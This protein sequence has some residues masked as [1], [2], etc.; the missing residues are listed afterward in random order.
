M[1]QREDPHRM[2]LV[3]AAPPV[4]R[5]VPVPA[6]R[7]PGTPTAPAVP[8]RPERLT[9]LDAYRGFIMLAMA[10]SS[11]GIPEVRAT[12]AKQAGGGAY[13]GQWLWDFLAYQ[14][15]HAPWI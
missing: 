11:L 12:L 15:D 5:E 9:S 6:P 2:S 8:D 1:N 14:T 13:A 3:T 4:H 7:I 10:A